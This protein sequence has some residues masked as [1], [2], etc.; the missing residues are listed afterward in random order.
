M[1]VLNLAF[2][3]QSANFLKFETPIVL[4]V[5][6]ILSP[7]RT[8][9]SPAV[10]STGQKKKKKSFAR[11]SPRCNFLTVSLYDNMRKGKKKKEKRERSFA[12]KAFAKVQFS[13]SISLGYYEK[14][15][16][17]TKKRLF[18]TEAFARVHC[19]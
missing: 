16:R 9:Y 17:K 19:S 18:A 7:M 1:A 4:Y 3:V 13:Y 11:H 14:R 15:R 12:A 5:T 10:C 2:S 6:G 8:S